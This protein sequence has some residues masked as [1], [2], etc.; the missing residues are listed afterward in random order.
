MLSK[1]D[2]GHR[3]EGQ[4][5]QD[6]NGQESYTLYNI[7]FHHVNSHPCTVP[8]L[9]I[10]HLLPQFPFRLD[11]PIITGPT[12]WFPEQPHF[13]NSTGGINLHLLSPNSGI[14]GKCSLVSPL[15]HVDRLAPPDML[16]FGCCWNLQQPMS[17]P[18]SARLYCDLRNHC[19]VSI[20]I[21]W[22]SSVFSFCF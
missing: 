2:T 9:S 21:S 1:I 13:V 10:M 16:W 12:P 6:C 11:F 17:E 18:L 22:P 8:A 3:R 14:D 7:H 5:R 20:T 15:M 4:C 19:L